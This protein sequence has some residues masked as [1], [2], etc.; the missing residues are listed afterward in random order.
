LISGR[1]VCYLLGVFVVDLHFQCKAVTGM[2]AE[3]F[4]VIGMFVNLPR[5]PSRGGQTF[6]GN[7]YRRAGL[8]PCRLPDLKVQATGTTA[9]GTTTS[10][11]T[12]SLLHCCIQGYHHHSPVV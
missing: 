6:S 9:C 12:T 2:C 10:G 1:V 3:C 4:V 11:T 5:T 7:Q 8:Q